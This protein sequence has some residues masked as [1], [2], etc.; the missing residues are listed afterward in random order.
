M[1]YIINGRKS[2][3][4]AMR[5]NCDSVNPGALS[6]CRRVRCVAWWGGG[7]VFLPRGAQ[8]SEI[9]RGGGG[10]TLAR[11]ELAFFAGLTFL[12]KWL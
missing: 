11:G 3:T 2:Q 5:T 6:G 10:S 1:H 8:K 12:S 7:L 9:L 4:G